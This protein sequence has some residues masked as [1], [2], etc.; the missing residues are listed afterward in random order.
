MRRI[1][2]FILVSVTVF[3]YSCSDFLDAKSDSS[4]A[5]PNKVRDLQALLDFDDRMTMYFPA[6]GDIAA[7]YY[8]LD[9]DVLATRS[10]EIRN[11]Y[12]WDA[13]AQNPEDWYYGYLK[14]FTANVVLD[15]IDNAEL[16]NMTDT[17]RDDVKGQ[18]LFFRGWT[19]F[20][21][22]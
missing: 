10:V 6:A 19:Y 21:L 22:S 17:Q 18:A 5:L 14:I 7:D 9:S 16:N 2:G 15:N 20:Q 11:T 8:F 4:L 1:I 3:F 12:V 13:N